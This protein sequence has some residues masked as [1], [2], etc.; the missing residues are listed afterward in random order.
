MAFLRAPFMNR[1]MR[2]PTKYTMKLI[3]IWT[4]SVGRAG[5]FSAS[6]VVFSYSTTSL[7]FSI[8]RGKRKCRASKHR[9]ERPKIQ[10]K[11]ADLKHGLSV[12]KLRSLDQ[13]EVRHHPQMLLP[14]CSHIL[15]LQRMSTSNTP[16]MPSEPLSPT[17]TPSA[18]P[19]ASRRC[20]TPSPRRSLR[21]T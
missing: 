6:Y 4:H 17:Q 21:K 15:L 19:N 10:Q 2:K 18:S 7:C 13:Y 12:V 3:R 9:A 5:M 16:G 11:F 14:R 1:M 8:Q 20:P